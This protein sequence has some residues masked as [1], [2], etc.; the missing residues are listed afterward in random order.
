MKR[1]CTKMSVKDYEH[2][3]VRVG[4]CLLYGSCSVSRKIYQLRHGKLSSSDVFVCHTCDEPLCILDEHHFLGTHLDNMRDMTKKGRKVAAMNRPEVLARVSAAAKA[5][6]SRPGTREK[7]SAKMIQF[8]NDNPAARDKMSRS[9][10]AYYKKPGSI[11][12]R[13][14]IVNRPDVKEKNRAAQLI[15]QNTPEVKKKKSDAQRAVML[16]PVVRKRNSEALMLYFEQPGTREK[17][18][19]AALRR[20]DDPAEHEKM[21]TAQ[22][23]PGTNDRRSA[24]IKQTLAL[25]EN[26][27]MC[28]DRAVLGWETRRRNGNG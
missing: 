28:R 15:V 21:R 3:A 24:S 10:R 17:A 7:L 5:A 26:S 1:G 14:E 16:D 4:K 25:P 9:M 12:K 19:K 27:K 18:S 13:I 11:E 6:M 23:R 2:E 20:F 22:N 8:Y